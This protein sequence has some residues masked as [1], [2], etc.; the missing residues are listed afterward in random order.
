METQVKQVIVVRADLKIGKGK[1]AVQ[2]AHASLAASEEA[3]RTS[4]ELWESWINGGQAKVV[5]KVKG[6]EEL[7]RLEHEARKRNLPAFLIRDRGLTQ[8]PPDTITAL[9][10]GPAPSSVLDAITGD[11]PLL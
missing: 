1:L 8:L 10:I 11:L 6:L 2:V 7:F 4:R 9:G 5:V 3:R